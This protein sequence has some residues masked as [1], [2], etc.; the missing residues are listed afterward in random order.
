MTAPI[1]LAIPETHLRALTV[2]CER[3]PLSTCNWALT[4]SLG[5]RL[6]GVD[7]PV[8]DIDVQT[9]T[10]GAA[11]V[12]RAL[13]EYVVEAPQLWESELMSSVFGRLTIDDILVEVMGGI[14]KRA[15]AGDAW[16]E[17]TDPA[18]HRVIVGYADLAVPVL[19]LEYEAAAYEAL[20]R[21]DRASLLRRANGAHDVGSAPDRH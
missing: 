12:A 5:H 1:P 15:A 11:T 21:H 7:V 14:R 8:H 13:A 17:A 20:S 9:D 10:D 4:G 19:S 2:I 3:L 16:G 6:Q 18:R